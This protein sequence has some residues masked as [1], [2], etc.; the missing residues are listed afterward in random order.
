LQW[1][2]FVKAFQAEFNKMKKDREY[3]GLKYREVFL[4]DEAADWIIR[5]TLMTLGVK[6]RPHAIDILNKL[7]GSFVFRHVLEEH[8]YEDSGYFYQLRE[9]QYGIRVPLSDGEQLCT[10]IRVFPCLSVFN[11]CLDRS[12]SLFML[13]SVSYIVFGP[14]DIRK[15][16]ASNPTAVLLFVHGLGDHVNRF[17]K[18]FSV[19]SDQGMTVLAY[20]QRGFGNSSGVRGK[21]SLNQLVS[22]LKFISGLPGRDRDLAGL[23]IFAYGHGMGAIVLLQAV[24]TYPPPQLPFQGMILTSPM[25][26]VQIEI[27]SDK[28]IMGKL[29]AGF[30][31]TCV[32][33]PYDISL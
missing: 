14:A 24:I 28:R 4:G 30:G 1:D 29:I 7:H 31:A 11:L 2:E 27:P 8:D 5:N 19:L 3:N 13:V 21:A 23:P 33:P 10:N 25:L 32:N 12:R 9:C 18:Y 16:R 20:D 17:E 6:T 15:W 26:G 22:D